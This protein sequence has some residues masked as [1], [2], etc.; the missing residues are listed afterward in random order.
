MYS[1]KDVQF[2][3]YK[4]FEVSMY[5]LVGMSQFGKSVQLDKSV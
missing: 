2:D 4:Q 3:K 1:G 5:S